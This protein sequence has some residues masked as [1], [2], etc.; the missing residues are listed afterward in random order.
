MGPFDLAQLKSLRA[1]GQLARFHEISQ[2]RQNWASAETL[3]DLF[4]EPAR[5]KPS[6]H[7]EADPPPP[8][9]ANT[10]DLSVGSVDSPTTAAA[11]DDDQWF[12]ALDG[13]P[14]GPVDFRDLQQLALSGQIGPSVL[15]WKKGMQGW[16]PTSSISGLAVFVGPPDAPRPSGG[17]R[18]DEEHHPGASFPAEP[19]RTSGLAIA[20]LVLSL[21]WICGLGSLLAVI[22]GAISLSQISRSSGRL[23]GKGLAIAGLV[24]GI[25]GLAVFAL[26]A[27]F[28]GFFRGFREANNF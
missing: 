21:V 11:G 16:T 10:Y 8:R 27:F 26:P 28:E 20:S 4:A 12:Y 3:A 17:P 1:R 13:K 25:L 14:S 23:G 2:D 6:A 18:R 5:V 24:L 15:V 9:D 7:A 22:F 19:A